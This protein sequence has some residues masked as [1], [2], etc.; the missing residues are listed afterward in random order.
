M[1]DAITIVGG[2]PAGAAAALAV[3]RAG[4]RGVVW[5]ASA[6]PRHKVCGEFYSPEIV[7]RLEELGVADDFHARRPARVTHAE[8][9]FSKDHRRFP[10]P[11]AAWGLSRYT[12][13]DL[14]LTAAQRLG[15]EVRRERCL[16]PEGACVWA[17]GRAAAG[18]R[19]RRL[20]GFKAHFVGPANDA[21]EL[22]FFT[23][24]Y[25][26]LCAIEDG[27]TNVC[28]LAAEDL[29]GASGFEIDGLLAQAPRLAARLAP[30]ERVTRWHFAGPLRFGAA[31]RIPAQALGAG[32][33]GRFVDPFTG[34]GLLAALETGPWA[35]EGLLRAI[36]GEPWERCRAEHERRCA[37]FY[38]RQT[39]TTIILRRVL[40]LGWAEPLAG[41]VPGPWLFRL[42]R[43]LPSTKKFATQ[44]GR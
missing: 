34:S 43:P 6:L 18:P 7:A 8:L 41:L 21:V 37:A 28:G 25:C 39:A 3:T 24:G 23:G 4:A 1:P 10:L 22:Y 36:E 15:A 29:L 27:R 30:L 35:G 14:L 19:G 33:A 5:E 2:G 11:E 38:G 20:F 32:D 31:E 12:F 44:P 17:A 42:T 13:D 16:A 26:G 40:A 9:H